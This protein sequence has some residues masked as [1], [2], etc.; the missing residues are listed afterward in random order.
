MF[1]EI[2]CCDIDHALLEISSWSGCA[3]C[4]NYFLKQ[5]SCPRNICTEHWKKIPNL[6][7]FLKIYSYLKP[8]NNDSV[9][10]VLKVLLNVHQCS[11]PSNITPLNIYFG[12]RSQLEGNFL[13]F[14]SAWVKIRQI[15]Q[16]NFK[17]GSQFLFKFSIILH[18]HD[19]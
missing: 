18:C 9:K 7:A 12:Q 15:P 4:I 11:V 14:L 8:R 19:K 13:R 5:P 10:H 1:W 17:T 16:V 2:L 3:K 6:K